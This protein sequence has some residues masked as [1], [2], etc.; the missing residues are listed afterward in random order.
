MSAALAAEGR[1]SSDFD[2]CH[3]LLSFDA[4]EVHFAGITN[5]PLL[6]G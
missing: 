5:F 2:F 4:R 3:R 1:F 6:G